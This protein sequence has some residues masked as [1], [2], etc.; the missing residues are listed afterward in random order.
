MNLP[1]RQGSGERKMAIKTFCDWCG[2]VTDTKFK[3]IITDVD[4]FDR[5][6]DDLCA[7]CYDKFMVFRRSSKNDYGDQIWQIMDKQDMINEL[8]NLDRTLSTAKR[9][10]RRIKK[11]IQKGLNRGKDEFY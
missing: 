2:I 5:V 6:K 4:K 11:E 10:L 3:L 8:E 9:V 7:I 1:L